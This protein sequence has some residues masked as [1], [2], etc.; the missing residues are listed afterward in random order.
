MRVNED[1]WDVTN[2]PVGAEEVGCL[3]EVVHHRQHFS[4]TFA[5]L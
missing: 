2:E 3:D 1:L 4:N 5:T